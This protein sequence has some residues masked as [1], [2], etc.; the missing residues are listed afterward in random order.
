MGVAA[1]RKRLLDDVMKLLPRPDEPQQSPRSAAS[2]PGG[3]EASP[4]AA[5]SQAGQVRRDT[6]AGTLFSIYSDTKRIAVPNSKV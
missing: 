6:L 2:G 4:R 5:S 3:V 1:E